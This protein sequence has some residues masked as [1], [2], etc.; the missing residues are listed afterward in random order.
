MEYQKELENMQVIAKRAVKISLVA[1]VVAIIFAVISLWITLNQITAT[2]NLVKKYKEME[3]QL[4]AIESK[5]ESKN[6]L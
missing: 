4:M 6:N 2:A 1:C 3:T 5:L